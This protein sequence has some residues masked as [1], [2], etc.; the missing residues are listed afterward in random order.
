MI[1]QLDNTSGEWN[2]FKEGWKAAEEKTSLKHALRKFYSRRKG[3][4]LNFIN[5]Y[6]THK[7]LNWA[8]FWIANFHYK[9]SKLFVHQCKL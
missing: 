8:R 2:F 1:F 4:F 6:Q 5:Y 3:I 9:L 7:H